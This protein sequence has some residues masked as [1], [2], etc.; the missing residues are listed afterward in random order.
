M[1]KCLSIRAK[2]PGTSKKVSKTVIQQFAF[3]GDDIR[4]VMKS[5]EP[6]FALPD[7]SRVLG[8]KDGRTSIRSLREI[9]KVTKTDE[10][11]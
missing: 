8:F 5:G 3:L 4:I 9:E 11:C 6:W 2:K 1:N 10:E 7:V